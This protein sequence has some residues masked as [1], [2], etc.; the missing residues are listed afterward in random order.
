MRM[1]IELSWNIHPQLQPVEIWQHPTAFPQL[2]NDLS[3][4]SQSVAQRQRNCMLACVEHVSARAMLLPRYIHDIDTAV[5][6]EC[7]AS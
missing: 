1:P 2:S 5:D 3:P 4:S 6:W 7:E